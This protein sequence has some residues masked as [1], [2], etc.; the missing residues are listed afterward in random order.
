MFGTNL[1]ELLNSL[2][3]LTTLLQ[4]TGSLDALQAPNTVTGTADV[5]Q[6]QGTFGSDIITGDAGDDTLDGFSGN[7]FLDGGDGS[8]TISGGSGSDVLRGGGGADNFVIHVG[9]LGGGNDAIRDFN[10][11]EDTISID[12]GSLLAAN[13]QLA[14]QADP[15]TP[16]PAAD[17][18]DDDDPADDDDDLADGDDVPDDDAAD[19]DDLAGD[20]TADGVP[21]APVADDD[22]LPDVTADDD[23]T[24]DDGDAVDDAV[25]DDDTATGDAAAA[26][27]DAAADDGAAVSVQNVTLASLDGADGFSITESVDGFVTVNIPGGSVVLEG[28]AFDEQSDSFAELSSFMTISD[29]RPDGS[30]ILQG[31]ADTEEDISGGAGDDLLA[32][33]AGAD[34]FL[35]NPNAEGGNDIFADFDPTEDIIAME[36]ANL[37][38]VDPNLASASP[39]GDPDTIELA[40]LDASDS[41]FLFP[42]ADNFV[43]IGH[44]GGTTT[45][46][47]V[48]FDTDA[49]SFAELSQFVEFRDTLDQPTPEQEAITAFIEATTPATGG[50]VADGGTGTGATATAGTATADTTGTGATATTGTGTATA[51][52]GASAAATDT[53]TTGT[54]SD[55]GAA[56]ALSP[57]VTGTGTGITG[58]FVTPTDTAATV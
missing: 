31:E 10:P 45:L 36:I 26:D 56:G 41:F 8:D 16:D 7:D 55:T 11:G 57:D 38:A 25:A 48:Q 19:G 22:D 43:V 4:T 9:A 37:N 49:D 40:D 3:R 5:D 30:A 53:A 33:G 24:D 20:D 42:S 13:P 35:L 23:V 34:N 51:G 47:G 12:L 18:P 6:L 54:T 28:V 17:Q 29:A 52:T 46:Q 14:L 21:E 27:D 1:T 15:V 58:G 2:S 44:P 39:D 32:G 50:G